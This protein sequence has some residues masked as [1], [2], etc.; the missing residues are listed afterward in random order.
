MVVFYNV[1]YHNLNTLY[2]T[3]YKNNTFTYENEKVIQHVSNGRVFYYTYDEFGRRIK[4]ANYM[5]I[6]TEY[7]YNNDLLMSEIN[8]DYRFDFLYD[9][10]DKLYGFIKDN[11]DTYYYVR[12]YL[13]NIIA[14]TTK[15]G[16]IVVQYTYSAY[17]QNLG[18]T[19]RLAS[20]IGYQN[21][22]RYKGYYYDVE[23]GLF[24]LSSRYY[25]P[26]LCR[27]I[28]PDD[29]GYLDPSSI[30]GL[31]LY[32]YCMNNPI[33]YAD[34]SGH[35]I[36]TVFDLFSLGA[37]VV[38]VVINP[39]NPWAW[40]GLVGDAVD[41][42]PFVSGVGEGIRAT[43]MVKYTDDVIDASYDTI[44]FVKAADMVDD[45]SDGGTM[46]RRVGNI[47]DYRTLT[48]T[49]HVDGT[50]LH[51][52]FMDNGDII[53]DS[54]T[55]RKYRYDGINKLTKSLYEL[56]PYNLHSARRGVKQIIKYNDI[57]GGGY[58]MIIVLY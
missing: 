40:A 10:N 18:F 9:S 38:E 6:G 57:L 19:G 21:P 55:Q 29:V 4:K 56:K 35:W 46:L 16:E 3:N 31:N 36:E 42:L 14:I 39:A 58:K 28:S 48:K 8:R 37:S 15:N 45:F 34:P 47:D 52:L 23:T 30:N 7:I 1:N 32:C 27:F 51:T 20:T 41:L 24:W 50:N 13:N 26:E 12:D 17:G 2:I 5:G 53:V 43:K 11:T 25:S 44:K 22:F 33:M 54:I 49:T